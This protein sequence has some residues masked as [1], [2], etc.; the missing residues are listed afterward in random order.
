M[1]MTFQHPK[2]SKCIMEK[3]KGN[4]YQR[5]RRQKEWKERRKRIKCG[6]GEGRREGY[7]EAKEEEAEKEENFFRS[8]EAMFSHWQL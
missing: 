8:N 6:K 4:T 1:I 2:D 5:R 7:K 3:Q